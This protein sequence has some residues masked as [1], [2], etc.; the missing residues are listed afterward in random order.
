MIVIGAGLL[1]IAPPVWAQTPAQRGLEPVE[2]IVED[3]GPLRR[4]LRKV[5]P[6]LGRVGQESVVY[7]R[8]EGGDKLYYI[9]RGVM[10]EFDRS[11]YIRTRRGDI[12]QKIPPNTVFHIAR[13]TAGPE[14]R[15][16]GSASSRPAAGN[17]LR[18]RARVDRRV[19][20][21][22]GV[23][24]VR[25]AGGAAWPGEQAGASEAAMWLGYRR[26]LGRQQRSV[27]EAIDRAVAEAGAR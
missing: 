22:G 16:Q 18:V 5:Q 21:G 10:A 9:A 20:H 13:P 11:Q 25:S 15:S 12:L 26:A 19:G 2:Q 17:A 24:G 1:L 23:G 7:R 27:A 6:G 3:T 14:G 8:R 4:S